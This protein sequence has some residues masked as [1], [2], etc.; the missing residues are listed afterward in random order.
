MLEIGTQDRADIFD[1]SAARPEPLYARVLEG[2][3]FKIARILQLKLRKICP[4]F[5]NLLLFRQKLFFEKFRFA[6]EMNFIFRKNGKFLVFEVRGGIR[7]RILQ[8]S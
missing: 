5:L 6:P 4:S 7:H 1:I 8:T 2:K 3:I